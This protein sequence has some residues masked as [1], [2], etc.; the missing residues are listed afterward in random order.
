MDTQYGNNHLI[1]L[2]NK[3]ARISTIAAVGEN[4]ELGK[5][6]DLIWRIK[7]DLARVRSLTTNHPIIMGQ[8]TYESIG[9]PLPNPN[10]HSLNTKYCIRS[11][12]LCDGTLVG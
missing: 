10:Q 12:R 4:R 6:N 1:M 9:R 11:R 3:S 8:N 2:Q 5:K 7:D